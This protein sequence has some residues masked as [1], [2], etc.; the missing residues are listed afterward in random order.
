MS[1][2]RKFPGQRVDTMGVS[3]S[4]N[5]EYLGFNGNIYFVAARRTVTVDEQIFFSAGA[6]PVVESELINP[7]NQGTV[8]GMGV[9]LNSVGEELFRFYPDSVVDPASPANKIV[10]TELPNPLVNNNSYLLPGDYEIITFVPKVG[11]NIDYGFRG[12][13]VLI[14]GTAQITLRGNAAA[15]TPTPTPTPTQT[16]TATPNTPTPTPTATPVPTLTLTPVPTN[17]VPAPLTP[18]PVQ[19]TLT[20]SEGVKGWPSFYSYNPDYMVG[21]NNY[22]YSFSSANLYRHNVNERRNYYYNKQYPTNL[23]TVFNLEPLRNK[24][25]K[26][27]SLESDSSWAATMSTDM[28]QEAAIA[29]QWYEEKEGKYYAA[30]K[31]VASTPATLNTFRFRSINGIGRTTSFNVTNPRIFNFTVPI[32]SIIA[33]GDYLYY[34]NEIDNSPKLAGVITAITTSSI[35]VDSTISGASNPTSTTPLMVS[36][37]NTLSESHGLLGHFMLTTVESS[38]AIATELFALTTDVFKSYP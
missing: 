2:L 29:S 26:T 33:I 17:P 35:T 38:D 20:Y 13:D 25:F 18:S 28:G 10:F 9:I 31:N 15:A 22:F 16:P 12:G 5:N 30:I 4:P 3:P 8:Q 24:V 27:L 37:K 21:M 32:D 36:A 19:Y 1:R 34:V 14:Q 6:A 7:P 23:T 11:D